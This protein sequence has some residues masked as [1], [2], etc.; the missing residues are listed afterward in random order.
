MSSMVRSVKEAKKLLGGK[1]QQRRFEMLP[2]DGTA[3][4]PTTEVQGRQPGTSTAPADLVGLVSSISSVGL[5]QP[6][7][8][9]D[10]DGRHRVV[11]GERR[12]RAMRWGRTHL[13]DNPHFLTAAAVVVPGPLDEAQR[14]SWQLVENLARDDLQP[15]EL[16]AALLLE[17]A[18][19]LAERLTEAGHEVPDEVWAAE[20]PVRRWQLLDKFRTSVGEHSLGAP[21]DETLGRVG[22]QLSMDKAKQVVRAFTTLPR[23]VSAEMDEAKVALSTRLEYLRLDRGRHDAAQAIWAAVKAQTNPRLLLG[24]VRASEQDPTLTAEEAVEFA[25]MTHA[26]ADQARQVANQ[27][28]AVVPDGEMCSDDDL[29]DE[30]ITATCE[31]AMVAL[32]NEL[33]IGRRITG[34]AAGTVILHS[35]E[36]TGRLT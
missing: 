17:R 4:A 6:I 2:I 24:A 34:Y 20:D 3:T 29:V 25:A 36:L 7:L 14:R 13:P 32:L 12:L 1:L 30:M 9:E 19:V 22:I 26:A 35:R 28:A 5:L 23:E 8:V 15:A 27:P 16:G 33:R 18:A 10:L 31:E 21:W 11:A